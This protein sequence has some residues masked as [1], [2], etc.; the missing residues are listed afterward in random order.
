[1][2]FTKKQ[3]IKR[4][5]NHNQ[6]MLKIYFKEKE[7]ERSL[8]FD[9]AYVLAEQISIDK[10]TE[11]EAFVNDMKSYL[12]EKG[13]GNVIYDGKTLDKLSID[14]LVKLCNII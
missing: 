6:T 4:I 13:Y 10:E 12:T 2:K 3:I 8:N 14:E 9:K 5:K 7:L 11:T 1:M